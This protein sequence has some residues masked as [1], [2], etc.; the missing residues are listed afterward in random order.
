MAKACEKCGAPLKDDAKFCINCGA[1][2][3]EPAPE[4]RPID[5]QPTQP[6]T[7]QQ[8][9][10][11]QPPPAQKK[12]NKMLFGILAIVIIA[13]VIIAVVLILLLGGGSLSGD[14]GKFVG[15]WEWELSGYGMDIS[16]E[17]KFDSNKKLSMS[18]MG[19]GMAEVGTWKV[20]NSK[21]VLEYNIPG[22]GA[23]LPDGS[24]NYEFSN[25]DNTLTLK[26]NS[27]TVMELNKK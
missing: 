20:E 8:A 11:Y 13:V 18:A 26:E 2:L 12:S 7:Q 16:Y 15:T 23:D 24:Y 10:N 14:E 22:Y 1:K 5:P 6:P 3:A 27:I 19:S 25:G 4:P 17:L 21:L 9:Y